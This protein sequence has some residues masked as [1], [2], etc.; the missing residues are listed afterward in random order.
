MKLRA[1]GSVERYKACLV[2]KGYNQVEGINY[3]ESL[4]PVAKAVTVLLFLTLAAA[5]GWALQQVD[6]NNAFLH[7]YLHEDF[8]MTP[9]AGYRVASYLVCKLERSL[10]GLKQASHQWNVEFTMKLQDFDFH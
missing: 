2:S 10:Y 9:P 1:D 7:G 8:Y 4:S 6:V 3:T 5:K